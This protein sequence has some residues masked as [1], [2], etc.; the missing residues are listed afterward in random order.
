MFSFELGVD[1]KGDLDIVVMVEYESLSLE[2]SK[3]ERVLG[4]VKAVDV[5]IAEVSAVLGRC[6]DRLLEQEK[7]AGEFV[8]E[9]RAAE[10]KIDNI[11]KYIIRYKANISDLASDTFQLLSKY[12]EFDYSQIEDEQEIIANKLKSRVKLYAESNELYEKLSRDKGEANS[13][14]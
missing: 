13:A 3:F 14:L 7:I 10:S 4:G 1:S 11:R 8:A 6:K 12:G 2:I 5:E 9:C